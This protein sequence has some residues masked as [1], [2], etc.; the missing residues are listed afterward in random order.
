MQSVC[1]CVG[2]VVLPLASV[3]WI[4]IE[5]MTML[6]KQQHL[7][8]KLKHINVMLLEKTTDISKS[9]LKLPKHRAEQSCSGPKRP[10]R[11]CS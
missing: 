5:T 7:E 3:L 4:W 11:N 10:A 6:M 2:S 9:S 1:V 8:I